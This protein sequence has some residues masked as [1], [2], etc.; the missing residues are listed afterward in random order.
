MWSDLSG[1]ILAVW[2]TARD[3]LQ[4]LQLCDG[5]EGKLAGQECFYHVVVLEVVFPP[6][7]AKQGY[8]PSS[9]FGPPTYQKFS[10][11]FAHISLLT[12]K[13]FYK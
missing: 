12:F 9:H 11:R 1:R 6:V 13:T 4:I 8:P 10:V 7:G 5:S 2:K 3:G